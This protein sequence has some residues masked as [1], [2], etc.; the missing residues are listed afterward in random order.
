MDKSKIKNIV[1]LVILVVLIIPQTRKPIQVLLQKGM[2]LINKPSVE[3]KETTARLTDY[4]WNLRNGNNTIYNLKEAKGR[5]I[6]INFWA[7][8]CPPCIAEMPSLQKLYDDYKDKIVFLFVTNDGLNEINPFLG[9]HGYTFDT[10]RPISN[11]S[12]IF[13]VTSIPRTFLIDK[14]GNIIVDESG[15]VNWSSDIVRNTIDGLLK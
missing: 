1:F 9:K 15:A 2:M 14:E 7:T 3:E 4:N 13:D 11:Y 5:I 8:W 10:Y 12:E 6:L